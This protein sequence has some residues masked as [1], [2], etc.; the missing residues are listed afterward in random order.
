[1]K[2]R[3][4]IGLVCYGQV[5][6]WDRWRKHL[7]TDFPET[8]IVVINNHPIDISEAEWR[9]HN[10]QFEFGAYLQLLEHFSDAEQLLLVNDTWLTQHFT[11]AWYRLMTKAIHSRSSEPLVLGDLRYDGSLLE[12]RPH[13]FLSSW[14]MIAPNQRSVEG[15]LHAMRKTLTAPPVPLSPNYEAFLDKWLNRSHGFAGWH[16]PNTQEDRERKRQCI[17]WEHRLSR[18]LMNEGIHLGSLRNYG[19][20]SHTICRLYDRAMTRWAALRR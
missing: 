6:Q 3:L 17:I 18:E 4:A 13:P 11:G 7:T 14:F 16:G 9:G 2:P 20:V 12:E 15:L 1:M 10:E 19:P 8:E 5:P